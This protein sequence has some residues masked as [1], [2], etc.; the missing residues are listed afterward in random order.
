M[1]VQGGGL[2]LSRTSVCSGLATPC[3]SSGRS[4]VFFSGLLEVHNK[5][6]VCLTPSPT[7]TSSQ[8]RLSAAISH[9]PS[10]LFAARGQ[11]QEGASRGR[12]PFHVGKGSHRKGGQQVLSWVL[13]PAVCYP[14]DEWQASVGH[15]LAAIEPSPNEGA[16][17][18]RK[19]L[20]PVSLRSEGGL[21]RL[22]GCHGCISSCSDPSI[23]KDVSLFSS[24][25]FY[26]LACQ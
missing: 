13:Q 9:Q 23:L 10:A 11:Q 14:Q 16:F 17:S 5:G 22:C 1:T 21:R 20:K 24:F 12:D 8:F 15:R 7:W 26:L 18:H 6:K 4:S 2:P 19:T 3:S 25:V